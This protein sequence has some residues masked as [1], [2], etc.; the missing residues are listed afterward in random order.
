MKEI[1]LQRYKDALMAYYSYPG[2]GE[3][4]RARMYVVNE[5]QKIMMEEF[6]MDYEEVKQIYDELYWLVH[7]RRKSA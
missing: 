5:Y 2:S 3:G 6:G 1:F 4:H 7:N